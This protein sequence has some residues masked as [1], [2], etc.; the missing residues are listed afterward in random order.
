MTTSEKTQT[1]PVS[2]LEA[3]AYLTPAEAAAYLRMSE[4]TLAN[5][6]S[7]GTGPRYV[8]MVGK[9]RYAAADLVAWMAALPRVGGAA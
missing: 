2:L 4:G 9:V 8:I 5:W 1:A 3:H 7:R 6:R